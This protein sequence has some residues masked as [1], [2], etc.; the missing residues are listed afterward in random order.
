MLSET[1]R[2]GADSRTHMGVSRGHVLNRA[3][4]SVAPGISLSTSADRA[5]PSIARRA[6]A[7]THSSPTVGI[8]AV[9]RATRPPASM[10]MK[11]ARH[12][13]RP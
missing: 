10:R 6:T 7:C 11:G 9:G 5:H 3:R 4:L 13:T 8:L 2:G 1:P 12:V